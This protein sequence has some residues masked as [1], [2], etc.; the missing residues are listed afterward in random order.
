ML[1]EVGKAVA[2]KIG[3][4]YYETSVLVQ[5]GIDDLFM[6]CVRAALVSKRRGKF[7]SSFGNLKNVVKPHL[8]VPHLPP[9]PQPP[10]VHPP[11]SLKTRSEEKM[12]DIDLFYDVIF[13]VQG[14]KIKA[15]QVYLVAAS[16]VF[17][18]LFY[19]EFGTEVSFDGA[20]DKLKSISI[21]CSL[22]MSRNHKVF[23]KNLTMGRFSVQKVEEKSNLNISKDS[24]QT[25]F[26]KDT[27][28]DTSSNNI[29]ESVQTIFSKDTDLGTSHDNMKRSNYYPN[30]AN[31]EHDNLTLYS[32][33]SSLTVN[34][35]G[36]DN[37]LD[38]SERNSLSV[39]SRE[40]FNRIARN[41]KFSRKRSLSVHE[42]FKKF[43]TSSVYSDSTT[44][45]MA[46]VTESRLER[47]SGCVVKS[48]ARSLS[49]SCMLSAFI[50]VHIEPRNEEK[51]LEQVV[52]QV[53][54]SISP[55][56]FKLVLNYL[57]TGELPE[58]EKTCISMQMVA[59]MMGLHELE[60]QLIN[61][62]NKEAF[63]NIEHQK[64]FHSHRIAKLR[65][66]F[67]Q[68]EL[69]TGEYFILVVI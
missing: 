36:N 44:P 49:S 24:V 47:D 58:D 18:A 8:Q 59:H 35:L 10:R 12:L 57:Y 21:E 37:S 4:F 61:I 53:D 25:I 38:Y 55:K 26:S 43:S 17:E 28:F 51:D 16:P 2:Q 33:N 62:V 30:R 9:K 31:L 23:N 15:H 34:G 64:Q 29:R 68:K 5:Y 60:A 66:L 41:K 50:N 65:E 56:H 6:N 22:H 69:Y 11:N 63:L 46:S 1:P 40:Y 19:S 54:E 27:A 42:H 52:V 67:V 14:Q 20:V 32:D 3:A 39:C 7:L 48:P 13:I 45:S